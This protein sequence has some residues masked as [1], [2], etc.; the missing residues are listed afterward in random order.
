M[1]A[2]SG[3]RGGLAVLLLWLCLASASAATPGDEPVRGRAVA[4]TFDDLPATAGGLSTMRE[5]TARL[6]ETLQRNR[7]PA[8][9]FVN[10]RKLFV[11]AEIDQRVAL[12]SAWLE[13][14]LDLGNHSFSHVSID[15]VPF[16]QYAEDVVRGETVTRMLLAQRGRQLRYYRHTQLRTGPTAEYKRALDEFLERRGYKI[17]PVTIDNNEYLFAVAYGRAKEKDDA[18]EM[19]RIV[20]AYVAYMEQMFDFYERLSRE[21]L[22]YEV[23]QTLLLHANELNADHLDKLIGMLRRRGYAFVTLDQALQDEAYRRPE[24]QTARGLSW[25]HRWMLA[26]GRPLKA[27]PR[28]PEFITRMASATGL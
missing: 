13:A 1:G 22:G 8:T 12:L 28:E 2:G 15:R 26:S 16:E 17:A 5:V 27:E 23:K 7:V 4:F 25:L 3:K 20:D 14:G 18:A 6:T 9:G 10:E 21:F 11:T 19:K 24:A